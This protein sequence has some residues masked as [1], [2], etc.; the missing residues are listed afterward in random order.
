MH[1]VAE[2]ASC[3]GVLFGSSTARVGKGGGERGWHW[4]LARATRDVDR[5]SDAAFALEAA[6][7]PGWKLGDEWR[8]QEWLQRVRTDIEEARQRLLDGRALEPGCVLQ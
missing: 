2:C 8:A 6:V 3:A 4:D 5:A 1:V 7:G